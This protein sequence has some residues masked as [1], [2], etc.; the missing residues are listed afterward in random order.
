M[1]LARRYAPHLV[2]LCALALL[3]VIAHAWLG[4]HRED[5]A[6]PERF[7]GAEQERT[8]REA[9]LG[10]AFHAL[11]VRQ[12]RVALD[13]G[14]WSLGSTVV[15]STQ[16]RTVYYRPEGLIVPGQRAIRHGVEWSDDPSGERLP[17]H[18]AWY[19]EDPASGTALVVAYL[20]VYQGRPVED[21][22][23]AQLR[24]APREV[25]IGAAPMTLLLVSGAV[26]AQ[27]LPGAEAQARDWLRKSWQ[28]YRYACEH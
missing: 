18:R 23:S 20:L 24:A 1:L 16:P 21:P 25:F 26:L 3:A 19:R 28:A 27:D 15:R 10:D 8:A 7:F 5:C 12:S 4:L 11:E 14:R 13:G 17:I 9:W 2:V 22:V 6:H